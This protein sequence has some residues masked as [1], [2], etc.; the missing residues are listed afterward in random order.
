MSTT[1]TATSHPNA[2]LRGR[3]RL[4][5]GELAGS[6]AAVDQVMGGNPAIRKAIADMVLKSGAGRRRAFD[7]VSVAVQ[8][9][10]AVLEALS[11]EGGDPIAVWAV[12]K[13]RVAVS[14]NTTDPSDTQNCICVHYIAAG[15]LLPGRAD[16]G[17]GLWTLELTDHAVGQLMARAPKTD[18]T[19]AIFEAHHAALRLRRSDVVDDGGHVR[20]ASDMPLPAGPGAFMCKVSMAPDMSLE[21]QVAMH[22]VGR[23][24]VSDDQ[25]REDQ[26]KRIDDGLSGER[27]GDSWLLPA[28]LRR[29]LNVGGKAA[30]LTW[31]G[32][33]DALAKPAGR[34]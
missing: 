34:A 5:K 32:L 14:V 21:R 24:W 12:L 17:E 27:L 7:R 15:R 33:P 10:G 1:V 16:I 20:R 31:R 19:A 18:R 26:V 23:T 8:Q 29:V 25:L 13:P 28:P 9:S 3:L 6:Y 11:L 2:E 4:W 22:I 30:V